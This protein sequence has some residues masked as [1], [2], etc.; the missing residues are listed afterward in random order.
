[1]MMSIG[2]PNLCKARKRPLPLMQSSP[3]K[4]MDQSHRICV[5]NPKSHKIIQ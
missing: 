5:R 2:I 4:A 3:L 1:M